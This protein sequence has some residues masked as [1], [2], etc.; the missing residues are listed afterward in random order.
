[1]K[2]EEIFLAAL[3]IEGLEARSSYLDKVCGDAE[4]RER[5]FVSTRVA[6]QVRQ[7]LRW[8]VVGTVPP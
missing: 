8:P 6:S 4:L 1:M 5:A 3:E 2:A 7:G